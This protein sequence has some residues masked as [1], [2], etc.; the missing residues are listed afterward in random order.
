MRVTGLS[1]DTSR[2]SHVIQHMQ[3]LEGPA[4]GSGQCGGFTAG[5]IALSGFRQLPGA[6]AELPERKRDFLER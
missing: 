2:M 3:V 5:G 4:R 1:C 6:A